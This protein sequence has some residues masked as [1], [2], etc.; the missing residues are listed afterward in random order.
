V[1]E[2]DQAQWS[3]LA[4]F[5]LGIDRADLTVPFAHQ[6][7]TV[8]AI[9]HKFGRI[10]RADQHDEHTKRADGA[11]SKTESAC[12]RHGSGITRGIFEMSR[13]R[14]EAPWNRRNLG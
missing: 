5:G 4:E 12:G 9:H 13:L 10:R 6:G 7:T 3:A 2:I 14:H 8:A 1:I 11:K